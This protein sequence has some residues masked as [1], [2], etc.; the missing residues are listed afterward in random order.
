MLLFLAKTIP[1]PGTSPST[2]FI[3][4]TGLLNLG[5]VDPY[6]IGILVVISLIV[7]PVLGVVVR[8]YAIGGK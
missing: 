4:G 2:S 1:T 3:R 7:N 6:G 5:G 8:L